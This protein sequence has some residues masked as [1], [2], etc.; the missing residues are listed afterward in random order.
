MMYVRFT[1]KAD[2][3]ADISLS[4]LCAMSGP[5]HRSKKAPLFGHL[6]GIRGTGVMECR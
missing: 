1:P 2:K 5:T 6:V 4:P 3:R